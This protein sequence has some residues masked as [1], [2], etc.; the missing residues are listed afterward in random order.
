MGAREARGHAGEI[1][2]FARPS[3]NVVRRNVA[4]EKRVLD[5]VTG[6]ELNRNLTAKAREEEI[7]PFHRQRAHEPASG[8]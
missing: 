5:D 6:G 8:L 3:R 2:P 1:A 7:D 4:G